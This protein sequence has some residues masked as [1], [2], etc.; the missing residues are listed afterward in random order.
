MYNYTSGGL[1]SVNK[2]FRKLGIIQSTQKINRNFVQSAQ[3]SKFLSP[4][5]VGE[6]ANKILPHV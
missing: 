3:G 1:G 4:A 6:R 5:A 2:N